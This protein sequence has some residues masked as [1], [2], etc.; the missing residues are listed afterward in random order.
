MR[1]ELEGYNKELLD[2]GLPTLA[3]GVGLHRGTGV[4]G[5]VGSRDLVQFAFVGRIVNLAA[6]VQDLTRASDADILITEAVR[7]SLDPRFM[8][9]PM[10]AASLR[11]IEKPVVTYGVEHFESEG[12]SQGGPENAPRGPSVRPVG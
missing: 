7:L 5:L 10:E 4:A 9:R 2:Q 11:G 6:R 12:G 1:R 3:I 8:L